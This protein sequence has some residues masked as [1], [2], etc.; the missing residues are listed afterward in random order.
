MTDASTT[1]VPPVPDDAPATPSA[2]PPEREVLTW[3]TFGVAA[4]ELAEQVV[5]R[6]FRPEVVVAVA[7]G[8]LLP[9]GAVA[10]AY[11]FEG[12]G[13]LDPSAGAPPIGYSFHLLSGNYRATY[14][15]LSG[16]N[17]EDSRVTTAAYGVH[18]ADRWI[19]D[20]TRV[21]A[22]GAT[23]ADS[24]DRHKAMVAPGNCQR[25][26]NTFSN[27]EGAFIANRA[28]PVRA[29]RGYVGANSGPTTYRV[30]TFYESR[31]DILTALRVHAIPGIMDLFDYA[32]AASG[33]VYRN[34]LN[35]GGVT[36]DGNPDAVAPGAVRWEMV[37]G[38]QG[39]L[40]M[41]SLLATDIPGF[42]VTSYY[43]DDST[44]PVTQCTGDAFEYGTSGFW[45]NG[46][47]PNTDPALGAYYG[48]EGRRVI[49]YAAPGQDAAFAQAA[50]LEAANPLA[51]VAAPYTPAAAVAGVAP[52]RGLAFSF[53]PNPVRGALRVSFALP[54]GGPFALRL[55]DSAGRAVAM[56]AEG[57]WSAGAH[58]AAWDASRL[59]PGVYFAR[60][61]G[62]GAAPL[63]LVRVR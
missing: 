59:A 58:E 7:R 63:R 57:T 29:L 17:P 16:P 8:G 61:S 1:S 10:Y 50:S 32:P 56:V 21:T 26:E 37:T 19:R 45:R 48:L 30:H 55:Y 54:S 49:A 44:P 36:I 9:G 42:T 33:M 34:D 35:P 47:I 15:V 22:G 3:E 5:E 53:E 13:S 25:T 24:L 41:T 60:A 40:A 18:F 6:G 11:L 12:D 39:T 23:G 46:S 4:R 43:S 38:S 20:E 31:E 2:A 52:P 27:G 62:A 28:G 51:A 14:N